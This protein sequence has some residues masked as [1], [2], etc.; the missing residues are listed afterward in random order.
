LTSTTSPPT[1][2]NTSLAAL[3]LSTIATLTRVY[4]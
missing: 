1:G 4:P 2:V 3:T